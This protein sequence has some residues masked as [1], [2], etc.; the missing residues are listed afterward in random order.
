MNIKKFESFESDFESEDEHNVYNKDIDIQIK[1]FGTDK[2]ITKYYIAETNDNM[3]WKSHSASDITHA[4]NNMRLTN[5][6]PYNKGEKYC[7]FEGTFNALT[8]EDVEIRLRTSR[9]N[10]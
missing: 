7:I 3:P 1:K 2:T 6:S 4:L 9:Y 10:L 5:K 8:S